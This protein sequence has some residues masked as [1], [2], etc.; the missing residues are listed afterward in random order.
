MQDDLVRLQF[1]DQA[2]GAFVHLYVVDDSPKPT[3]PADGGFDFV[4]LA[5]HILVFSPCPN[6]LAA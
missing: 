2:V 1:L 5:A 6:Q 4:A 3:I